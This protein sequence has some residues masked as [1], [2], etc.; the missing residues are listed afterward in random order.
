[1]GAV[2]VHNSDD[3]PVVLRGALVLLWDALARGPRTEEE[4]CLAAAM[5]DDSPA[6]A[7]SAAVH[8]SLEELRQVGL[9]ERYQ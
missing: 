4:L 6:D 1:M 9:V 5:V 7:V 2:V 3:E 8:R